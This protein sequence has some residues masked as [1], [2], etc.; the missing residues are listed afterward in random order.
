MFSLDL[1]KPR[2]VMPINVSKDITIVASNRQ[3]GRDDDNT[4]TS[5]LN[6]HVG[7]RG[8]NT[9]EVNENPITYN[10]YHNP[11]PNPLS[12]THWQ[13]SSNGSLYPIELIGAGKPAAQRE[14]ANAPGSNR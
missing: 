8:N 5:K 2:K 13:G 6:Y 9:G 12:M 14:Q 3:L 7:D 10:P 1:F 11:P 4:P